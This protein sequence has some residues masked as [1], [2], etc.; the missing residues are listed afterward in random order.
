V[1]D[2]A[3][4][5]GARYKGRMS[6]NLSTIGCTSFFPSKPLGC[7]GDGGAIFTSDGGLA[8]AMR[9]IRVHGQAGRYQHSR[10]GVGGR[11]DTLQCAVVLAK[12][13]RFEW[14]ISQRARLAARYSALLA[15]S[16]ARTPGLSPDRTNV[17]AQYTLRVE[18]RDAFRREMERLGVPTA[19]HYPVPVHRQPAYACY[20]PGGAGLPVAE[21]AAAEVVSLPMYADMDDETQDKVVASVR[22]A[23]PGSVNVT[24]KGQAKAW[25]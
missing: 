10:I 8:N 22:R 5:F 25:T 21:Q 13:G 18:R 15:D 17:F 3:Q 4:S 2:A 24:G 23:L 19:V 7:Y 12:L 14:E 16:G 20:H 1:E 11:M 9:E 6:G